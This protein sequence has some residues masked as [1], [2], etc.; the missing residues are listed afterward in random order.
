VLARKRQLLR[1]ARL[2]NSHLRKVNSCFSVIASLALA[3]FL[4]SAGKKMSFLSELN[5]LNE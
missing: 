3:A 4:S 2:Q 5:N 1:Y